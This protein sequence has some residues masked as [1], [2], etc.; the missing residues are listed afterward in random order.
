MSLKEALGRVTA[1]SVLQQCI[2][3]LCPRLLCQITSYLAPAREAC[4]ASLKRLG[5]NYI[6]LYYLHRK[7]PATPIEET[8]AELKVCLAMAG[9]GRGDPCHQIALHSF[10]RTD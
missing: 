10:L 4:E 1:F 8:M 3:T 6:D 9:P 5:V 2:G 7:D